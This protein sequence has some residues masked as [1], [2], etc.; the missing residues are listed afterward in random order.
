MY[1][2]ELEENRSS[3]IE[4]AVR[5]CYQGWRTGPIDNGPTG[6]FEVHENGWHGQDEKEEALQTGIWGET[7][8]SIPTEELL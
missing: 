4:P 7:T 3:S 1:I 5:R 8:V 2:G 6:R